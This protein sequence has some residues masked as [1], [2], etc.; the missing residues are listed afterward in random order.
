MNAA[1]A[2]VAPAVALALPQI[3]SIVDALVE[4]FPKG[5]RVFYVGAGTS[6]R[7]GVLDASEWYPTFGT[8]QGRVN[9]VIAGGPEAVFR[10]VEGA[11]DDARQGAL[12][13]QSAGADKGDVVIGI[14]ASGTT[15]YVRGALEWAKS[16]GIYTVGIVCNRVARFPALVTVELLTGREFVEGSS[17]LK[18]GTATKMALNLIS[19]VAMIKLGRVHAGRMVEVRTLS[20]KLRRRAEDIVAA[21]VGV[22]PEKAQELLTLAEG[23]I[24]VAIVMAR[25]EVSAPEARE[26]LA[27]HKGRLDEVLKEAGLP[28]TAKSAQLNWPGLF[29]SYAGL[30]L[31][32]VIGLMSGTSA[33]GMHAAL[34]EIS[35]VGESANARVVGFSHKEYSPEIRE[36]IFSLFQSDCSAAL[37]CE[38]N[39]A[40]GEISAQAALK[41]AEQHGGIETIHLIASHGQT[42]AHLPEERSPLTPAGAT[43]Q[44]GEAAVIAERTGV[45]TVA[46]FRVAEVATGGQ[47]APLTPFADYVLFRH[48]ARGRAIQNLG[49]IGNVTFLPAGCRLDE[50]TAFDTGPGNMLIDAVVSQL[51]AGKLAYD[52][53][54]LLAAS[55]QANEGLL[56]WLMSHEFIHRQPPKTA[57][58]EQFGAV[59]AGQFLA[60]A[61][62]RGLSTEDAIATVTVFTAASIADAYR[63]FL[64]AKGRVDE[65]ILGGG[66]TYNITLRRGIEERLP[67]IAVCTHEDF[68]IPGHA[69][70]A[71][72]FALLGNETMLGH[73]SSLPGVT[74][75]GRPA[76]LG[77]IIPGWRPL[78]NS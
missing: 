18:A 24:K 5:G 51:T 63:R 74:G 69:K 11:E 50:I 55:G 39:F 59:L 71:L 15:P 70:E 16:Q 65:V 34:V 13:L 57:G 27:Q 29:I 46:D 43:L 44:I 56:A 10:S 78:R 19:T 1:D 53:D 8:E 42:I 3:A 58:R 47:G 67:G 30:P 40:L 21:E 20:D 25:R 75:A 64:F 6:G 37:I 36:R 9:A 32:R 62:E 54:G 28:V 4:R 48:P 38:M 12:D 35:G 49:G 17:R 23:E 66:G 77:K 33:D 68:G 41:L 60:R 7:L 72:A 61:K 26:K 22:S 31:R 45:T 76:L 2:T 73:P 52:K 14:T